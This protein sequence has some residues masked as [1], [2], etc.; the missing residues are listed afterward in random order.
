MS[1]NNNAPPPPP[2]PPPQNPNNKISPSVLN[3][4]SKPPETYTKPPPPVNTQTAPKGPYF[5]YGTLTD[6]C[7]LAEILSL[8]HEPVLRPAYIQGYECRL[9]GQY[10]ALLDAG[11][12]GDGDGDAARGM[13][14][15]GAVY[16]VGS[17]EDGGKLAAYETGYYRAEPCLIRYVDG[18]EPGQSVGSTFKF[19]GDLRELSEGRFDLKVWLKRMGRMK[20]LAKLEKLEAKK[21]GKVVATAE[22][23]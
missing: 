11:G 9:W 17:V 2:P 5:L 15:E 12:D 23:N 3:L 19:V 20:A 4:R 8:G 18:E 22:S 14:V 16:D 6:P 10:P 7:M 13:V 21:K 1:S